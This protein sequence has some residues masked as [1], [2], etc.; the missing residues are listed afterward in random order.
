MVTGFTIS[1]P[2]AL[3]VRAVCC[4]LL[5][6]STLTSA[7]LTAAAAQPIPPL[8]TYIN[9]TQSFVVNG[10][11]GGSESLA[12]EASQ[13]DGRALPSWMKFNN[14][15]GVF[16]FRAPAEEL[17]K[18]YR[19][20][21]RATDDTDTSFYI[22][23]DDD[24][25][26]CEVEA[27]ADHR[28]MLLSCG[29][30]TVQ[31]HGRSSTGKYRWTGPD[32]F[33]SSS[34]DPWVTKPGL[35]LLDPD[36]G[37]ACSRMSI[38]EVLHPNYGC[39]E[40]SAKNV[41]PVG[42]ISADRTSGTAPLKVRLDGTGSS[43]SD[44]KVITYSWYWDGGDASGTKPY[45]TFPEG[46]HEVI[47]VVTDDTGARSTDRIT[48]TA[49]KAAPAVD[50]ATYTLEAECAEV[51]SRWTKT[52][53]GSAA[54]GAYVVSKSTSMDSAPS[55]GP[56]NQLRFTVD[57]AK[58]GDYYLFARVDA[59]SASSDS[60]WVR[61][62]G[63]PWIKWY[64]G[65]ETGRGFQWNALTNALALRVGSN[66]IDFA[67]R[68]PNTKLDKI[69]LST[70]DNEPDGQ[71][72]A[73][74]NCG[75]S[76]PETPVA[77]N[78]DNFWLEA[79]C[80]SVG[81]RWSTQSSSSAASGKYVMVRSGNAM[82][83]APSD[84]ADN[85][86][87]F[88]INSAKAGSYKLFARIDAASNTDDSF[89]VRING[90]NWYK[91]AS[92]IEQRRGFQWNKLPKTVDL[93]DGSNVIDFAFRED[94]TKL[95]KLF[96]TKS[97]TTPSGTGS[98][99]SNCGEDT[100][101]DTPTND[102]VTNLW[103]EAECGYVGGAWTKYTSS[104]T[105]FY[106][107]GRNSTSGPSTNPEEYINIPVT[108][109]KAGTYHL[110]LRMEAATLTSNSF[111]VRVD[112]G[113]WMQF[114]KAVGGGDLLTQGTQWRKVGHDGKDATFQLGA[115]SHSILIANREAGTRL[116]RV[117]LSTSATEPTGVGGSAINCGSSTSVEMMGMATT[118]APAEDGETLLPEETTLSLFPNP[119]SFDLTVE[120]SSD[121]AGRV[122]VLVSDAT[123][124]QVQ[125]LHF[126]KA[127][128]QLRTQL[129]VSAL[130][131]GMYHLRVL[132]G[133]R[134]TMKPFVKQ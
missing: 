56:D 126:D 48:I 14:S 33:T 64:T 68:E 72:E 1:A 89:W 113:N 57:V 3:W 74:S 43:D 28:G 100:P 112:N 7:S 35:Y 25:Q 49:G 88:S 22:L 104:S 40:K 62:N 27:N 10:A 103:M 44:G 120:L 41:I 122:D 30:S 60:Y 114:W 118:P 16:T 54:G 18:V 132:E 13:Y 47:L 11:F 128:E 92:G 71:G 109:Q 79:E 73:G 90:G 85:R 129:D 91:W 63:S 123:G 5:L 82:T 94:G 99:A 34:S 59:P 134:Q 55:D 9:T 36:G 15:T 46:T 29:S 78:Q 131:N 133:D 70:E 115:G 26:G 52:S 96:L 17:G 107:D 81:S 31:L 24:S 4:V 39:S 130:P 105:G 20:T 42:R 21:I 124:R 37:S 117:L 119:V 2:R 83:S 50:A 75:S 66:R 102:G 106:V 127:G 67:Y 32:G 19:I 95:D 93:R 87:R 38:V 80:A 76:Q 23:I 110:F 86:V 6:A 53:S 84:I 111:W 108:V 61:V 101:D 116:D 77:G 51:G 45:V 125:E 98:D 58:A 121:Y 65:F 12:Y 8:R 69:V 97:S